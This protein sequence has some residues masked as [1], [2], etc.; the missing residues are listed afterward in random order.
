M[1]ELDSTSANSAAISNIAGLRCV[2]LYC[3][4]YIVRRPIW[5]GGLTL[6]DSGGL[7]QPHCCKSP[8]PPIAQVGSSSKLRLADGETLACPTL[9]HLHPVVICPTA[10]NIRYIISSQGQF[11]LHSSI[12]FPV[13]S[14][15][16]FRIESG[17]SLMLVFDVVSM[18]VHGACAYHKAGSWTWKFS[19]GS[20][21]VLLIWYW[22]AW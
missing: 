6:D 12:A 18:G 1:S 20:G 21:T 17:W 15:K 7:L 13:G 3:L 4:V 9:L 11:V 2:R 22:G 5:Y 16:V 10:D 8:P 14:L 19:C